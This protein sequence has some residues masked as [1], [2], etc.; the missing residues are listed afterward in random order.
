MEVRALVGTLVIRVVLSCNR[1]RDRIVGR[2]HR[3]SFE[4]GRLGAL[5][6]LAALVTAAIGCTV[7]AASS[8]V[9]RNDRESQIVLRVTG[10]P[11]TEHADFRI[12]ASSSRE[13]TPPRRIGEVRSVD[14]LDQECDSFA[15]LL[16]G[17]A[18]P[19]WHDLETLVVLRTGSFGLEDG[20][21]PV[22]ASTGKPRTAMTTR[23]IEVPAASGR[24][25]GASHHRKVRLVKCVRTYRVSRDLR[26]EIPGQ[27]RAWIVGSLARAVR[28]WVAGRASG[29]DYRASVGAHGR[30]P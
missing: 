13:V 7:P 26:F 11:T 22:S 23:R 21:G 25:F 6:G 18:V 29:N 9:V 16:I 19:T 15:V 24:A 14:A 4:I 3:P 5:I 10:S 27:S 17:G 30:S 1:N 12:P 28:H 2:G 20:P 8:R